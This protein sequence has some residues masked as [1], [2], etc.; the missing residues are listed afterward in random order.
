MITLIIMYPDAEGAHFDMDYYID[1]HIVMVK[2]RC[3]DALKYCSVERGLG[4][5]APGSPAPYRVISRICVD[6]M[7]DFE[8]YVAPHDPEFSAD[9]PNFTNIQPI[10]Q[11]D[12]VVV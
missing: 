12:E 11:I 10:I 5:A 4:G 1:K 8:K 9:V 3:G 6:S 2:E 7:E